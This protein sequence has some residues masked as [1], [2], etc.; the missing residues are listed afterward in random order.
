MA[1]CGP[2]AR[3]FRAPSGDSHPEWQELGAEW[4]AEAPQGAWRRANDAMVEAVLA[5]WL[6]TRSTLL[7]KTDLF[8]EAGGAG[9]SS[10]L[11]ARAGTMAGIDL[12]L[13]VASRAR[14]ENHLA[15]VAQGDVR[16]L[17]FRDGCFDSVVSTS[18]L[19]H[20]TSRAEI[21]VALRE[22]ARVTSPGGVL[23]LTLD[24]LANPLIA[25]RNALP[26]RVRLRAGLTPY[27]V[28]ATVGPRRLRRLLDENGFAV[29]RLTAV[30]HCP[31]YLFVALARLAD[32][33]SDRT[34]SAFVRAASS[35]EWLGSLPTRYLSGNFL[36]AVARRRVEAVTAQGSGGPG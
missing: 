28:G 19:D 29:E 30:V 4:L 15:L 31:R 22:L 14:T 11:D 3:G 35:L 20:F 27:Y 33:G 26:H 1:E 9:L 2:G 21:G 10:L 8:E 17:P 6:P 24:N 5:R 34:R 18:T 16:R 25:L 12:S 23:A 32:R 7:L 13:A 36:A